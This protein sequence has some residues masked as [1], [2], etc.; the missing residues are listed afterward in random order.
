MDWNVWIFSE[1]IPF[2]YQSR[3]SDKI[4]EFVQWLRKLHVFATAM[5]CYL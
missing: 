4:N 1:Q 5:I 2:G 3:L